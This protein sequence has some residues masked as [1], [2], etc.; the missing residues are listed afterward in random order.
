[1]NQVLAAS[2]FP[3]LP[4]A[5]RPH[6][7]VVQT[8]LQFGSNAALVETQRTDLERLL[9]GVVLGPGR[10][11][12]VLGAHATKSTVRTTPIR[13]SFQQ[14]VFDA[15]V[16]MKVAVSNYAMHLAPETRAKLF[17]DLDEVVNVDDWYEE[18]ALPNTVSF[19]DFLKWTIYSKRYNWLSI[20][21][22]D[23][24]KILVAWKSECGLLTATFGGNSRVLWTAT[25]SSP[26]GE[27]YAAGESTLQFFE[28]E[29]R[30]YLD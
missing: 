18:D 24:G 15:R 19:R 3:Q 7:G 6:S 2:V 12:F 8:P 16:E 25:R 26:E 14:R 4:I 17:H 22:S 20:G 10:E 27:T 30:L 1:M 28:R 29:A 21:F 5:F 11:R 9:Q 13:P 23:E